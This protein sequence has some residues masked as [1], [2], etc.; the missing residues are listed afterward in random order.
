MGEDELTDKEKKIMQQDVL[1]L[2]S[3]Q[4]EEDQDE[5]IFKMKRLNEKLIDQWKKDKD[6][7]QGY[8]DFR[9]KKIIGRSLAKERRREDKEQ[10]EK[11]KKKFKMRLRSIYQS[12]LKW[13]N[14]YK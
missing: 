1:E 5:W 3:H 11:N 2:V 6:Q 10:E 8:T 9:N 7:G 14:E 4:K 12:M 13:I